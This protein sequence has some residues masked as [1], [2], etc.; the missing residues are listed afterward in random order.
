MDYIHHPLQSSVAPSNNVVEQFFEHQRKMLMI[1]AIAWGLGL[2]VAF[3]T[4]AVLQ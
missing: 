1:K 3:I 2:T 4:L